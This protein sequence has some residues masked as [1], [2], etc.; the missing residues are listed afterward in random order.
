MTTEEDH[1]RVLIIDG[2]R[3]VREFVADQ[4]LRP[5]GYEPILAGD[6]AEGLRKALSQV[7]DLI[8]IDYELPMMSA[9]DVLETLRN[10][11]LQIPVI[12]MTSRGSEYIAVPLIRSGVRDYL[13]KPFT[14]DDL[15]QAIDRVLFEVKLRQRTMDVERQLSVAEQKIRRF[16]TELRIFSE[17]GK[18][19]TASLALDA[20][21]ERITDAALFIAA[22]EECA[23]LLND[24]DTG[25]P[26]E[27]VKRYM[28]GAVRPLV[29]VADADPGQTG[30]VA[31]MLHVP[32]RVGGKEI[33][34][35][36]VK[37]QRAPRSFGHH[38]RQT[39]RVLAD[40]AAIAI[41]RARLRRRL[42]SAEQQQERDAAAVE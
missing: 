10:R 28:R 29:P 23:L 15:L 39:L 22:S 34:V 20:F 11:P 41:E 27:K 42:E 36:S 14:S 19:M 37:N 38:E 2:S 30:Q 12:L 33:G 26:V 4:V 9:R 24:P 3:N 7:P 40:Y 21:L 31:A 32:L 8:L 18:A 16:L 6:G 25:Q 1:I 13:I 17:I 35:L 5:N